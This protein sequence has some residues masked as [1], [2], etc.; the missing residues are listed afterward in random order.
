[1]KIV[2][3]NRIYL[4][5][6]FVLYSY[7]HFSIL[8]LFF[9][10]DFFFNFSK[11]IAYQLLTWGTL[12]YTINCI[13]YMLQQ[14]ISMPTFFF[15][16][17]PGSWSGKSVCQWWLLC[18]L[19]CFILCGFFIGYFN[20]SAKQRFDYVFYVSENF[21]QNESWCHLVYLFYCF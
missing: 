17:E 8:R 10:P 9:K 19:I 6:L 18:K 14:R 5:F 2:C 11:V 13:L 21:P 3:E 1:M 20:L 15:F 7:N 12:N 4:I 16:V